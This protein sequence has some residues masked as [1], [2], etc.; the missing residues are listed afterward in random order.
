MSPMPSIPVSGRAIEAVER[1]R[2]EPAPL[3]AILH[4]IQDQLGWLP[5][6]ELSTVAEAL[7]IPHGDLYGVVTFYSYFRTTP[8]SG[9]PYVCHGPACRMRAQDGGGFPAGEP[10]ACPGRCETP[11][12][13]LEPTRSITPR[14]SPPLVRAKP[15]A[16]LLAN[17]VHADQIELGAARKRGAWSRPLGS[18]DEIIAAITASGLTGRG[19]AGFPTG[20]K[21][22]AVGEATGSPK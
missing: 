17:P 6:S 11:I 7:R 2:H 13:Q 22:K 3:L 15:S 10:T 5:E 1:H 16:V 4:A 8:P 18:P 21:W 9:A 20:V 12:A 19:G 14:P